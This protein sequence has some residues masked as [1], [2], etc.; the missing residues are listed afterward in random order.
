MGSLINGKGSPLEGKDV[1]FF[2][3]AKTQDKLVVSAQTGD[4]YDYE[5]WIVDV[6]NP[7]FPT[8]LTRTPWNEWWPSFSPDDSQ[9]VFSRGQSGGF[10]LMNSNVVE[11]NGDDQIQIASPGNS[12]FWAPN[13]RRNP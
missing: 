12:I 11:S 8:R 6:N 7:S 13:W 10:F 5:L 4:N 9:I 3:W 2:D 1:A